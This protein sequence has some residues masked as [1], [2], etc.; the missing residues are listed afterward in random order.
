M[1]RYRFKKIDAFASGGSSGNPAGYVS[2]LPDDEIS[3]ED[4]QRIGR[5]LKGFVSETG[6]LREG[7]PGECDLAIRYFSCERE[8][9]FCGHATIAIMDDVVR[10]DDRFRNRESLLLKTNKGVVTVWNRTREDG[11]VYIRA[12]EPEFSDARP[13]AAETAAALELDVRDID[14]AIPIGVVNAGLDTM[15][16]PLVSLDACIRCSP[17]YM[18]LRTFALAHSVDVVVIYTRET[19]FLGHDLHSRVFAPTFGYLEDPAT[20]SG[21]A[22]LGNFLIRQNLWTGRSLVIE[23]GPD[24]EN[25]NIV[26]LLRPDDGG[27]M[28]GG[29][30]Q[31]RI[32]GSYV[33]SGGVRPGQPV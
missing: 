31:V 26:R 5:E 8:V 10:S 13:G 28:F 30:G 1:K 23:Q 12:P 33:L 15:L 20:G 4:M 14:P 21:N 9:E 24:R 32:D 25:P 7:T 3:D 17:D 11:M 22:A 6:F 27:L 18:T 16:V 19:E 29:G 2:L